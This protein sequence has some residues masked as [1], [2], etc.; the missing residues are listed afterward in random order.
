MRSLVVV[1]LA[2]LTL[3]ACGGGEVADE[4]SSPSTTISVEVADAAI[5]V[6]VSALHAK[7]TSPWKVGFWRLRGPNV[8]GFLFAE[9]ILVNANQHWEIVEPC[10]VAGQRAS[11]ETIVECL[12]V[13]TDDFWGVGNRRRLSRLSKNGR[14]LKLG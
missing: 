9:E 13:N 7:T 8:R 1:I 10:Q 14:V 2:A 4:E 5:A 6:V 12:T 11:G 3:A